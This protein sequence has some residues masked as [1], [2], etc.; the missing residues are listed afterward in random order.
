[1]TRGRQ[2]TPTAEEKA[3]YANTSREWP[4]IFKTPLATERLDPAVKKLWERN[5]SDRPKWGDLRTMFRKQH[6]K[7]VNPW[8][9]ETCPF[10]ETACAMAFYTALEQSLDARNP[11]GYFMSVCR[12]TGAMRAD[13]GTEL[14]ARM[15]TDGA[16]E[17][18]VG[19]AEKGSLREG[20][21]DRLR[22]ERD[23]PVVRGVEGSD[24]T[25]GVRGVAAGPESVGDVLRGLGVGSRPR[26][27][28]DSVADEGGR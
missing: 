3:R 18:R 12:S 6:C 17:G 11:Y 4:C 1:M 9:S 2:P 5:R 25:R 28:D 8:G 14:R 27:R 15:R 26:P 22:T 19:T 23:A 7:R 16:D 24:P 10:E 20:P 21:V 13:L